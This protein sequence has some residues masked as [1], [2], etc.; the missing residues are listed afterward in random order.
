VVFVLISAGVVN[1]S[2]GSLEVLVAVF[3]GVIVVLS[4]RRRIFIGRK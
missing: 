1:W 2:K 3:V 4:W